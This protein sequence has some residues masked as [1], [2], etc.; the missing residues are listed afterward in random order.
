MECFFLL[1]NMPA[2]LLP[3]SKLADL[4]ATCTAATEPRATRCPGSRV[5]PRMR[6]TRVATGE[7]A[8]VLVTPSL[9]SSACS[10]SLYSES[11]VEEEPRLNLVLMSRKPSSWIELQTNVREDF[12]IT[13]MAPKGFLMVESRCKIGT[14]AQRS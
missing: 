2:L 10:P 4:G 9:V 12:K 3:S 11:D 5:Q 6:S 1:V 8:A 13:E 14:P 7:R